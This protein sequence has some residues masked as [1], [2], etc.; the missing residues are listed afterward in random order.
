MA[1]KIKPMSQIKQ[2]LQM[3]KQGAGRKKIAKTLGISKTTV[4][5]YLDK[6]KQLNVSV[7]D[8]LSLEEPVLE[9][10]FHSG[11]PSYKDNRRYENIKD[12]F[13]YYT[14]EL[15]RKGVTRRLLWEEYRVDNPKG[16]SYSQF[17]FHLSQHITA[18]QPSLVL[19]HKPGEK[20][21]VDFAGK[22]MSYVDKETGEVIECP[23]FVACLPYSDYCFAMALKSQNVEEFIYAL[24]KCLDFIG[25]SPS[26]LVTDNLKAAIIKANNYEPKVNQVLEDF[27]NHYRMTVLPTR[28]AKPKDKALVEN[29][30]K[31]VYSRVFARLRNDIFFDMDSLN[32]AIKQ[33]IIDHNQTRMQQKQYCREEKFLA[34]EKDL[35]QQLPEAPFEIKY[36]RE[37]KVSKNNHLYLTQDKHY[38]SVPYKWIGQRAKVIYTRTIVRIFIKGEL[39]AVHPR[40]VQPHRYTT[41]KEHLCSFHRHY[42]DRSPEYYKQRAKNVSQELYDLV[43]LLFNGGRL[44]EQNYRSCDGYFSIYRKTDPVIFS[45][46]CKI[47]LEAKSSSYGYLL[48][49]IEN[50]KKI[51][52]STTESTQKPLPEH[53]NIRG[54]DYYKQLTL[55]F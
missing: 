18:K 12:D 9:V 33:K 23:V 24:T 40:S 30:V 46:A 19:Q 52:D 51:P 22:K 47:A 34:E 45:K 44:P 16:Y 14:S 27:A 55:K 2:L 37:Y 26:I 8:L 6:C 31:L 38:Y 43:V 20:L 11:N 53:S 1:G 3:Y 17:C 49:I 15:K 7:D 50:L 36:Y 29:Q 4:K 28:V 32:R 35:L 39:V 10:K 21:F 25:G 54:K 13:S 42:L 41:I 48:K 5:V